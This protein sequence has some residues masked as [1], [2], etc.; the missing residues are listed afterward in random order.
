VGFLAGSYGSLPLVLLLGGQGESWAPL[1]GGLVG[2][3]LMLLI[4]V[5]LA[6][7]AIG[8]AVQASVLA[9]APPPGRRPDST[10]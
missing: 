4:L 10:A 7:A 1:L 2:A 5:W 6:L 9:A 8:I 3:V